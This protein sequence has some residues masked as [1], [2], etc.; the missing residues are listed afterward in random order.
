[1]KIVDLPEYPNVHHDHMEEEENKWEEK[2]IEI[3]E[4]KDCKLSEDAL[5]E[6]VSCFEIKRA[7]DVEHRWTR[8]VT[9]LLKIQNNYYIINWERGLTEMQENEYW[10][11]PQ[12]VVEEPFI[13]KKVVKSYAVNT[14]N[15]EQIEFDFD[16]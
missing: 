13:I 3:I 10:E 6:L 7:V 12:P 11:Q 4:D 8:S 5:S 15:G 2:I 1:M 14:K 16:S 9:S